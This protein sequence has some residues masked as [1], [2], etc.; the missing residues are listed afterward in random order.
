M[1]IGA[2]AETAAISAA[3]L[4]S[5]L[6]LFGGFVALRGLSPLDVYATLFE[7]AFGT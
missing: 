3:A 7:G 2:W 5:S 6:A 4:V 1:R